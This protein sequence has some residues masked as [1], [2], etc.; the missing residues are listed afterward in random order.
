MPYDPALAD[1]VM[2]ALTAR[3][4]TFSTK[5]MFGGLCV[6]VDE[7]KVHVSAH[8]CGGIRALDVVTVHTMNRMLNLE[9]P[10]EV[11]AAAH[12]SLDEV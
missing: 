11:L 2:D 6:M 9:L 8:S 4:V 10:A 7:K 1:R 3:R 5:A 12:M